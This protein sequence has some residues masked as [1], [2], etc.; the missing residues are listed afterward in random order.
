LFAQWLRGHRE[1]AGFLPQTCTAPTRP[2]VGWT[3]YVPSLSMGCGVLGRQAAISLCNTPFWPR[4]EM[5]D[6]DAARRTAH[7]ESVINPLTCRPFRGRLQERQSPEVLVQTTAG[8]AC[9]CTHMGAYQLAA[10]TCT[11]ASVCLHAVGAD[12]ARRRAQ[13]RLHAAP[14]NARLLNSPLTRGYHPP[15]L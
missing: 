8:L 6:T 2:S 7:R 12:V 11:K 13:P 10:C 15:A 4:K 14:A 1:G 9:A 3:R 5:P